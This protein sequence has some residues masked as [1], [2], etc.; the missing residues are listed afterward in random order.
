M[1]PRMA[2]KKTKK[3]ASAPK[4]TKSKSTPSVTAESALALVKKLGLSASD[5]DA[6]VNAKAAS[7]AVLA[8]GD[9][10]SLTDLATAFTDDELAELGGLHGF[11]LKSVTPAAVLKSSTRARA[12]ASAVTKLR[13]VADA[14]EGSV[15]NDVQT[16]V[17]AEHDLFPQVEARADVDPDSGETWSALLAY[18]RAR[19][20]GGKR[21]K[22]K[23]GTPDPTKK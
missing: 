16:L 22:P 13:A 20:P 14:V 7:A 12:A 6:I 1:L 10:A 19:F 18:H 11:A 5:I 8:Q 9:R 2:A 3:K 21:K 15:H 4:P 17:K 23:A